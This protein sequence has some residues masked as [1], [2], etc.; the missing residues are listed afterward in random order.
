MRSHCSRIGARI[1]A[2]FSA[3]ALAALLAG[4]AAAQS[5]NLGDLK[6]QLT[7]YH[8][9]GGYERDLE[10]VTAQAA[11]YL[12]K[13]APRAKN[14]AIVF[15]ID[16]TALSTWEAIVANDFAYLDQIPCKVLAKGSCDRDSYKVIAG[17]VSN[18]AAP[19]KHLCEAGECKVVECKS[20]P[21]GSCDA[22]GYKL[23]P[24]DTLPKGP[25]GGEAYDRKGAPPLLPT[26]HLAELAKDKGVAIFFITGRHEVEREMTE[27][28]LH[29]AGYPTWVRVFMRPDGTATE[30]AADFKAPVREEI[31]KMGYTIVVN[32]G[33]QPSDL[34]GAHAEVAFLL[35]NPFYRIP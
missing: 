18:P 22:D 8:D 21:R 26:L 30:S 5:P 16:D 7:A 3:S 20:L 29:D 31:E 32:I 1:L 14:P 17:S 28:N 15:D 19:T 13:N 33:D 11:A 2:C 4:P 6:T 10:A 34:K 35:P 23:V 25:C 12:S 27:K 24:C 9:F